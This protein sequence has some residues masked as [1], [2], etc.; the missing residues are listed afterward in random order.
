[1]V[2]EGESMRRFLLFLIII[3]AAFPVFS[4]SGGNRR[5]VAVQNAAVKD[6][7]GFFARDLGTLPLGEEVNLVRDDGKWAQIQARNIN[8]WVSSSSLSTRR[9]VASGASA[10][11]SEVALAGKGFSPETEME[12]RKSGLDYSAVDS[13][14]RLTIPANELFG[15]INEGH[16]A[17]GE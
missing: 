3:C 12:Y 16:L 8:G 4:Q 5:Y 11:V 9:V 10:S 13:M 17:R 6:S 7:N 2:I 14:E 15:F 1:M